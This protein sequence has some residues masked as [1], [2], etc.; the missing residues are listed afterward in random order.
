MH[1]T[2]HL[3]TACNMRCSYCYAP[4]HAGPCMSEETAWQALEFGARSSS[5]SCG[6][7]FFGGEPLLCADLVRSTVQRARVLSARGT[8]PFHFKLTTNGWLLDDAI[9]DFAVRN[10]IMIAVSIDGTEAMHDRHR[11]LADGSGT[12]RRV[13]ANLQQLLLCKPYSNVIMVVNPDT[14]G[15]MRESVVELVEMGCR[16]VIVSLNYAAEWAAYHMLEL[17]NQLRSLAGDYLAW[18]RGGRKFYL[19]PFEGKLASHI[20]G[21][22]FRRDRCELAQR[23]I[24]V[25]PDGNLFPCVQFTRA[26]P[27]SDWCIGHVATGIDPSALA[28]VRAASARDKEPCARCAIRHRCNHTCGCLNWQATGSVHQVSPVLCRY[29]RMLLQVVDQVGATLFRERNPYFLHKHYNAAYPVLSL[30]E[31][32]GTG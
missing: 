2:L 7:V 30:L 32:Q 5:R 31:D 12:H 14:V 25:D 17:E 21:P 19:S 3:T 28:R 26:G 15:G 9:I 18:T 6:V 22:A 27:C 20:D 13:K 16:Y 10:D 23:Q 11:R 29:E 24:S 8:V 1:L 4:P